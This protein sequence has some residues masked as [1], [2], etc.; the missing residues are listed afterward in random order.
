[1]ALCFVLDKSGSMVG[2]PIRALNDG[3][4]RFKEMALRDS[5]ARDILDVAIIEFDHNFRIL[6]NFL[7]VGEMMHVS[8][9]T[10]RGGTCFA[11]PMYEAIR[12]VKD[13]T[14]FYKDKYADPY[15]PWI[16]L[17]TDGK[18]EP[19]H[20]TEHDFNGVCEALRGQQTGG[21]LA[22]R[23][24]G[25]KGYDS[26]TLHLLSDYQRTDGKPGWYKNVLQLHGYDFTGF[27][28]WVMKSM[29]A[30]SQNPVSEPPPPAPLQQDG[31][32]TVDLYDLGSMG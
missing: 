24:L 27:F 23:S 5:D 29:A 3:M 15:K 21:K 26:R 30:I 28:N 1:M 19:E 7:P 22:V 25:V 11:P 20:E 32:V 12:M 18:R 2:E 14:K 9:S 17:I 16:V 10:D 13:R 8:L 31:S 6:Q 4:N